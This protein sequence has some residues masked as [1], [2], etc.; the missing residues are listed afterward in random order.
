MQASPQVQFNPVPAI[1]AAAD[2]FSITQAREITGI[3]GA[4]A[5]NGN[6]VTTKGIFDPVIAGAGLHNITYT[7]TATNGCIDSASQTI[8]VF[9]QPVA[10]AGP[11]KSLLEGGSVII[12]ATASGDI[13][14]YLWT[15]NDHIS[16]NTVLVPTVSPVND[17]T[18]TLTVTSSDNCVTRDAVFVK[19]LKHR[20][21][22]TLFHQMET[23]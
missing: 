23:A 22:L 2:A 19:C 7:Y 12:D 16:N 4:F 11:D 9:P 14:S 21:Y 5:F 13:T 3:G 1:C 17:I 8:K 18:Y 6:G 15:P 10:N 20:L